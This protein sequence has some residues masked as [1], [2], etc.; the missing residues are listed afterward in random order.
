MSAAH[1]LGELPF[2]AGPWDEAAAWVAPGS[3]HLPRPIA[4]SAAPVWHATHAGCWQICEGNNRIFLR[5]PTKFRHR[6]SQAD[7]LHL[8]VWQDGRPIVFDGGSFSYH[9][10]ERFQ[11]LGSAALHNTVTIDGVEPMRKFSPFLYLPWPRG[12][13]TKTRTDGIEA[14]HD[15]YAG[16]SVS[17]RRRVERGANGGFIVRDLITG[18][19]G[20]KLRWHWRLA[21]RE[22][23]LSED[24]VVVSVGG[25]P[26]RISWRSAAR[27]AA[28]LIRCD[29]DSAY[30]WWSPHYGEVEP[31][32]SLL[33][34]AESDGVVEFNT[35]FRPGG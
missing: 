25:A 3:S 28:R 2:P 20:R 30:G 10:A 1:F 24:A 22:W 23:N 34:E 5:C 11:A 26:Y 15:G 17:W 33:I 8:E 13:A 21:D 32:C 18:A 31:A 4:P 14:G 7:L 12:T 35:E 19:D 27:V 16:M 29:P 6:P 9:S